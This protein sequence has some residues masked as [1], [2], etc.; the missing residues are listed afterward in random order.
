MTIAAAHPP[1]E[2]QIT[3]KDETEDDASLMG[4]VSD[5][6]TSTGDAQSTSGSHSTGND[7]DLRI[8]IIHEEEQNVR[9]A[10][11]LVGIAFLLCTAAVT[12]AVFLFTKQSNQLAFEAEVSDPKKS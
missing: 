4:S 8:K 10:R 7:N 6:S 11:I 1:K 12:A 2:Q 3:A 5:P 9:R